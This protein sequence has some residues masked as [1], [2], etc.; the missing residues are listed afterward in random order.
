MLKGDHYGDAVRNAF[1]KGSM[2]TGNFLEA[3]GNALGKDL[4]LREGKGRGDEGDRYIF[5]I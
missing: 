2:E 4:V 3:V 5:K 1:K